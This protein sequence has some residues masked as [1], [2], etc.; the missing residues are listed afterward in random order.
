MPALAACPATE[1][2]RLGHQ[3]AT[4][5]VE[6]PEWASRDRSHAALLKFL[7]IYQSATGYIVVTDQ[8]GAVQ[9]A[10]GS[11]QGYRD[12]TLS[13]STGAK[14]T[15]VPESVRD[16]RLRSVLTEYRGGCILLPELATRLDPLQ[17]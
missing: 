17:P 3:L 14:G 8:T 1:P 6:V 13:W 15:S 16:S 5:L 4:A 10:T 11:R 9:Y 12:I 7:N 2:E